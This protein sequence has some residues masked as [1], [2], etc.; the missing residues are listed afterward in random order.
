MRIGWWSLGSTLALTVAR[1]LVGVLAGGQIVALALLDGLWVLYLVW[2]ARSAYETI[3]PYEEAGRAVRRGPS[4]LARTAAATCALVPLFGLVQPEETPRLT[5]DRWRDEC[6]EERRFADTPP[7]HRERVFLCGTIDVW[8][9]GVDGFPDHL[10]DQYLLGYGRELCATP[11]RAGQ[12]ALLRRVGATTSMDRLYDDLVFLCPEVVGRVHPELLR[13]EAEER[14]SVTDYYTKVGSQCSDPWPAL[15]GVR[16]RT[17]AYWLSEGGG[18]AIYDPDTEDEESPDP[19]RG[20]VGAAGDTVFVHTYGENEPICLTA[21]ALRFTPPLRLKG[22][23]QVEEVGVG[24]RGGKLELPVYYEGSEYDDLQPTLPDLA[25]AGPGRYRVRVYIRVRDAEGLAEDA[26][27]EEHL[28]LVFPGRS[29]EKVVHA[30]S[31]EYG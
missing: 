23:E 30:H 24:S 12:D 19:G 8:R 29:A 2:L 10:P 16:Q 3:R 4:P 20:F 15:R 14:R 5:F 27:W 13:S 25:A 1:T 11:D 21:K 26:P 28:V 9:T 6:L 18:Y 17:V 22:W 7:R 31:E